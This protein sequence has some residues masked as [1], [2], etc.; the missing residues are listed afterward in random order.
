MKIIV[1]GNKG[2][3][4]STVYKDLSKRHEVFGVDID[5]LDLNDLDKVRLFFSEKKAD[6]LINLFGKNHH[7]SKNTNSE[8]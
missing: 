7:I 4:G 2:L 3:V 6:V 8:N 1:L 5:N